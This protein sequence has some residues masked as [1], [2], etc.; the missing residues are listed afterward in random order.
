[1]TPEWWESAACLGADPNLFFVEHGESTA[2]AKQ[3]CAGCEV[4]QD[5]LEYAMSTRQPYGVWGGVAIKGRQV[6]R[7]AKPSPNRCMTCSHGYKECRCPRPYKGARMGSLSVQI[8]GVLSVDG[9]SW[10][11][12]GLGERLGVDP[13]QVERALWRLKK[14]QLV[15][16]HD[17]RSWSNV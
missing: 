6:L 14:R 10:S 17:N 16:H 5:C 13:G 7:G 3:I 2:P 9:G 15:A 8:L 4:R 11:A 12:H 1:M